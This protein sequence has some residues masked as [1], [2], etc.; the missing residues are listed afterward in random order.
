MEPLLV[1]TAS[2]ALSAAERNKLLTRRGIKN[3]VLLCETDNG[4]AA[5]SGTDWQGV[6]CIRMD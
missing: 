1:E 4:I 3:A 2:E 5:F 6:D